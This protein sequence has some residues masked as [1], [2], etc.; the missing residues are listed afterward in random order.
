MAIYRGVGGAGEANDDATLNAI[1]EQAQDAATSASE[2][3]TPR[4]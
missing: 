3:A 4:S 2:A 1:T